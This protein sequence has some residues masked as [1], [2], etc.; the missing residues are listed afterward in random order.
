MDNKSVS[1]ASNISKVVFIG[2][3][4]LEIVIKYILLV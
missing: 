2:V 1:C 3:T 4:Y